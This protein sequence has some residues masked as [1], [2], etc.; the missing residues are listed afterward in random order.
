MAKVTKCKICNEP[1]K[2]GFNINFK[3]VNVCEYCA[4]CIFLQ[5]ATWYVK[6][7]KNNGDN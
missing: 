5:Q 2:S 1:T 7:Y 3:L 6:E 4:N